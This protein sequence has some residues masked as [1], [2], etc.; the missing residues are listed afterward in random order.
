MVVLVT[1]GTGHIGSHTAAELIRR[2]RPVRLLVRDPARVRPALAPLGVDPE[3]AE[4][5]TGDV[6]DPAAVARAV[7][8]CSAVVHAAAVYSL[9]P[10]RRGA[11]WAA[12]VRGAETVLGAARS[13]GLDPIVHV[14]TFGALLPAGAGPLTTTSPVGRPRER[15]LAS[16]AGAEQVAR[17]H[18][19]QG[20][21]VVITYP[22]ATLGPH[23]PRMG[24]QSTRIRD[25]L[26]GLMPVWPD[27]GYPVGDVRDLARLHAALL[28]PGQGPRRVFGPGAY[29]ST[30]DLLTAL[31]TVTG[32]RLPV[33]HLPAAALLPVTA[34]ADLVSRVTGIRL[35][36]Q[37][38]AVYICRTARA[39][40]SAIADRLLGA[41]LPLTETLAD[42]VSWLH[43]TGRI[44]RRLAG[45]AATRPPSGHQGA[46]PR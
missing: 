31:R 44:S 20:A 22:A 9:D 39:V 27:G 32:R 18:Q 28:T 11:M 4:V 12:N 34:M 37:Y 26:R 43:S 24:D 14:S 45:R 5:V 21:P 29:V 17:R 19:H 1:G 40:D 42:T 25:M 16:K 36:A 46:G 30:A 2:D 8:G 33:V 23:D 35:P 6:T 41:T 7:R 15:Y 13:A 3:A 38:G 10:R